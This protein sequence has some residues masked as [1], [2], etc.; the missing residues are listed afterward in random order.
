MVDS[1]ATNNRSCSDFVR[2]VNRFLQ[3]KRTDGTIESLYDHWILGS[4]PAFG[5]KR[6]SVVR[7]VLGWTDP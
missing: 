5:K 7:D 1:S 4:S 2:T 6:W 3:I